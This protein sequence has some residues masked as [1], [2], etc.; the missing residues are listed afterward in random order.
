MSE[1]N[2]QLF[3]RWFEEVWNQ[4]RTATI[5]ELFAP[6]GVSHGVDENGADIIGPAAFIPFYERFLKAFPDMKLKIEDAIADGDKVLIRWSATMRHTGDSLGIA[7][8]NRPVAIGGMSLARIANGQLVEAWDHW[9][10][11]A[12]LQ[13]I[14]AVPPLA[15]NPATAKSANG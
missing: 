9:D 8:T 2:I 13:Q 11:L 4:R 7:A 14:G 6:N 3:K 5:T 10:K 1:S 12:M 15:A